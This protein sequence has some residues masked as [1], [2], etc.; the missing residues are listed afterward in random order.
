MAETRSSKVVGHATIA[1]TPGVIGRL[2]TATIE[3][4]TL[5][6]AAFA[7]VQLYTTLCDL[8]KKIIMHIT[9]VG[10]LIDRVLA[11]NGA[12]GLQALVSSH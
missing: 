1:T 12:L 6:A 2:L 8:N 5:Q 4:L 11:L 10:N 3:A 7:S 9:Q